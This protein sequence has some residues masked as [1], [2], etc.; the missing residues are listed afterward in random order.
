MIGRDL[1][2]RR[3]GRRY[4]RKT[5]RPGSRY[6]IRKPGVPNRRTLFDPRSTLFSEVSPDLLTGTGNFSF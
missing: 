4:E 5:K 1:L 6:R 2:P 3:L